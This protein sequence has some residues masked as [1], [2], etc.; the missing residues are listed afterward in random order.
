MFN[1][2]L[3]KPEYIGNAGSEQSVYIYSA[4]Y[5]TTLSHGGRALFTKLCNRSL[6]MIKN[7]V[8]VYLRRIQIPFKYDLKAMHRYQ[9]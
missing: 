5:K 2:S 8:F 3:V 6:G 7:G 1:T 4:H 9:F